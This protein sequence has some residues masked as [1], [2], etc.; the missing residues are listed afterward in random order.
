[1]KCIAYELKYTIP[2][3]EYVCN[4]FHTYSDSIISLSSYTPLMRLLQY[5]RVLQLL[6]LQDKKLKLLTILV[7]KYNTTDALFYTI[8]VGTLLLLFFFLFT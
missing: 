7:V 8:I 4:L 3:S 1:M 5:K 6:N 2:E